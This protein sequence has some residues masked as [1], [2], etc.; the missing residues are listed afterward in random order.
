MAM[1][2]LLSVTVKVSA[3]LGNV[4]QEKPEHAA[5]AY[6]APQ[7]FVA[8]AATELLQGTY[9]NCNDIAHYFTYC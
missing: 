1:H 8:G 5:A 6:R 4:E 3:V 9:G 7:L 2:D